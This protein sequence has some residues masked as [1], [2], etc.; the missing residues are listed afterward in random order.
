M[1]A[2]LILGPHDPKHDRGDGKSEK[3]WQMDGWIRW[4][5]GLR[6]SY[7]RRMRIM[8]LVFEESKELVKSGSRKSIDIDNEWSVVDK[9]TLFNFMWPLGGMFVW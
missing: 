3:G 2:E 8:C 4:L 6:G 5:E 9:V 7:E 1:I